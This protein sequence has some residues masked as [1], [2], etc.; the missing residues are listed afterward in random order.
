MPETPAPVFAARAFKSAI[1]GTPGFRDE[2][3]LEKPRQAIDV[4]GMVQPGAQA[5]GG[6]SPTKPQGI[7]LTPGTATFRRKTVSFGASVVD[8]EGKDAIGK[9]GVPNDCPGKFPSPYTPMVKVNESLEPARR[10]ALIETLEAARDGKLK[11][12]SST[13]SALSATTTSSLELASVPKSA[14]IS[15]AE[16]RSSDVVHSKEPKTDANVIIPFSA[17]EDFDGDMTLDINEPHSHSGR[18]WKSEYDRYHEEAIAHM[19]KLV[20]YKQLAKSYAKKKDSEAIDLGEKLKEEQQKVANM[21]AKISEL[22]AQ[23]ANSRLSGRE[24]ANH[25]LMKDLAR[26]TALTREYGNQVDEFQTA[27]QES[28]ARSDHQRQRRGQ[29][30]SATRA[31]QVPNETSPEL[32]KAREQLAEMSSLR[33]EMHHLRLN[34]SMAEK[35]ASRL[36]DE[37]AKLERDLTKVSEQLDKSEK[38]RQSAEAQNHERHILLQSLRKDY[39]ILK[40]LAKSQRRDAEDLLKKRHTQVAKLKREIRLLKEEAAAS[41][42]KTA[43]QVN[44]HAYR[45]VL[46]STKQESV[47]A[48][49]P[50]R[51]AHGED[52]MSV[53]MPPKQESHSIWSH[54]KLE[55]DRSHPRARETGGALLPLSSIGHCQDD[56]KRTKMGDR[57]N[58]QLL[59]SKVP[60]PGRSTENL[61]SVQQESA[62]K[63][64][65][66]VPRPASA[67]FKHKALTEIFN[68]EKPDHSPARNQSLPAS[69]LS[70]SFQKR[71]SSLS[72]NSPSPALLSAEP[73]FALAPRRRT[74]DRRG[75]ASPRPSMFNIPS[76]PPKQMLPRP[77]S[78]GI[79]SHVGRNGNGNAQSSRMSSMSSRSRT[80]LSS[81]RAAAAKARLEQKSA[82]KKRA[83]ELAEGKENI[84]V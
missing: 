57:E 29:R 77:R 73:S 47:N 54:G 65:E 41:N 63:A 4:N 20:K 25:D 53:D 11:K 13:K 56:H 45:E 39:D 46:T 22:V 82:E 8:N 80:A 71:F 19:T 52:V 32:D 84:R 30:H 61:E 26:Q 55:N 81:D 83:H 76:S 7:L 43:D 74:Q 42:P 58:R 79:D 38:R 70:A 24:N 17:I 9:S 33:D 21:E 44:S 35:K 14:S 34:L 75:T 59:E 72:L 28:D 37:N 5:P 62:C 51:I 2:D 60:A 67:V 31:E 3:E 64:D 15:N 40:E 78:S 27:I 48:A 16:P 6:S 66:N 49:E 36:Q 18:Y 1:F 23:I 10:T 68:D 50:K 69:Q 12:S